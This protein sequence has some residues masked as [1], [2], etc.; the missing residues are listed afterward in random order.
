[1]LAVDVL[2]EAAVLAVPAPEPVCSVREVRDL[3]FTSATTVVKGLT[4]AASKYPGRSTCRHRT[5]STGQPAPLALALE[6]VER[7][8]V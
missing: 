7:R 5:G 2:L 4:E 1:M 6:L 8:R 3:C